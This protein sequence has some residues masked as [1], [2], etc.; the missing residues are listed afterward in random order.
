METDSLAGRLDAL[1][2]RRRVRAG[3]GTERASN[4]TCLAQVRTS[5]DAAARERAASLLRRQCRAL[6]AAVIARKAA[7]LSADAIEDLTQDVLIRLLRSPEGTDPSPAYIETIAANVLIDR[8]RHR[9]RRGLAG[10]NVSL[11][12]PDAVEFVALADPDADTENTALARASYDGLI[13]AI[14]RL[15]RPRDAEIVLRRADGV[16][17]ERIAEDLG[18]AVPHVRKLA[19]RAM[20][21]LRENAPALIG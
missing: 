5:G 7:G 11:D 17:H 10:A 6:C 15:L 13:E 1:H 19:E 2:A 16:P 9:E 8:H 3:Q 21:R 20:R 4:R 14:R 18:L 12:D